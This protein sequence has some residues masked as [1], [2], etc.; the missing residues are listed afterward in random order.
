M[1]W[2]M[3][4]NSLFAVLLRSPWWISLVL[5]LAVAGASR[6]LLGD[7]LWLYGAAGGLPFVVIA[8]VA[9]WRQM[10]APSAAQVE[11]TLKAVQAMPWREFQAALE[12]G[13]QRQG[14]AV[15][16]VEGAAD[17]LVRQGGRGT[18]VCAR[19]WKA[20][21]HGIETLEALQAARID[22]GVQA[23]AYVALGPLSE[24]ARR[25]AAAHGVQVIDA[26]GLARL[27]RA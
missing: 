8:A 11:A 27:L 1:R 3:A 13:Y 5:A 4:P 10:Q 24:S 17:L 26:Q 6:A 14:C 12:R 21:N 25:F 7:A 16:R 18:L 22:R 9:G 23:S 15:E 20:G 19:R 2:K